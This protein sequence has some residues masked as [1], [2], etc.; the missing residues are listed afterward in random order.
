[1]CIAIPYLPDKFG[2][3][4]KP[5]GHFL[6][7]EFSP[8]SCAYICVAFFLGLGMTQ[9]FLLFLL[10][11]FFLAENPAFEVVWGVAGIRVRCENILKAELAGKYVLH[12][13]D[14]LTW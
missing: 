8:Y 1:L 12:H 11:Y 3:P 5:L 10:G 14:R 4:A 6:A 13:M 9:L 7:S 2:R